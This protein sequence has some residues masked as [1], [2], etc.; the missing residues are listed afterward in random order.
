L[1]QP[2]LITAARIR[3]AFNENR[4]S[5]SSLMSGS[6]METP[7]PPPRYVHRWRA[8]SSACEDRGESFPG[9]GG[10]R[11]SMSSWDSMAGN[12]NRFLFTLGLVHLRLFVGPGKVLDSKIM[13]FHGAGTFPKSSYGAM[14]P[15]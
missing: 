2:A 3:S 6:T 8:R 10:V 14:A 5:S 13:Y 1:R 4:L 11:G 15:P 12:R 9:F 7:I